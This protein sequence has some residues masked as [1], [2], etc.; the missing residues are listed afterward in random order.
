[1]YRQ[2]KK[3]LNQKHRKGAADP[4]KKGKIGLRAGYFSR[5]RKIFP[6]RTKEANRI[7]LPISG[8]ISP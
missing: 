7:L 3:V 4:K 5:K 6:N 2:S 8:E 1:L